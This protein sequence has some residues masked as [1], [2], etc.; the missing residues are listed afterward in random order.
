[1]EKTLSLNEQPVIKERNYGIDLLRLVSML[2][3]VSL[4]ILE[5]YV[6][7]VMK[8][9]ESLTFKGEFLWTLEILCL[10]AVNIYALISGFVGYKSRH[11][12]S[13]IIYLCLQL[14]FFTLIISGT[15]LILSIRQGS[16]LSA[17]DVF[18]SFFPSIKGYWYFSAYFCLFFFMPI[19]DKIIESASRKSLKIAAVLCFCVFCCFTQIFTEVSG[20]EGGYTVLWL[21][22]LYLLGAYISR[23]DPL[24]NWSAWACFLGYA[25]CVALTVISRVAIGYGTLYLLD[26]IKWINLL[27]SYTSPTVTVGAVFVL[28]GFSKLRIGKIPAKI[29]AFLSPM[30]FGVYLIHCHPIIFSYFIGAFEWIN[31]YPIWQIPLTVLAISLFIFSSCLF[32][33]GIRLALFKLCRI[34]RL[35]IFLERIIGKFIKS[36]LKIFHISLEN[37]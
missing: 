2:M 35:S 32:I 31:Q 14:I 8:G 9:A 11:K 20:L 36:I 28:C 33:D 29:I 5:F 12:A 6:G 10:G 3:V 27:V 7:G 16:E 34:K 15:D 21:V 24:K 4:H 18:L 30:A 13:N 17:K 25:V 37:E 23:Y 26:E 1:M 19:L 22:L